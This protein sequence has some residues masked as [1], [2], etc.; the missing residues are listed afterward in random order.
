[1][2]AAVF[3]SVAII[4]AL[5]LKASRTQLLLA[6]IMRLALGNHHALVLELLAKLDNLWLSYRNFTIFSM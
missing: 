3:F 4:T 2:N 6:L 1:M 5:P